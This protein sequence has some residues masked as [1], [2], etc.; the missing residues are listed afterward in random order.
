MVRSRLEPV[1]AFRAFQDLVTAGQLEALEE[2]PRDA[3]SEN[4]IITHVYLSE[5]DSKVDEL[6]RGYHQQYPLRRGIAR[7]ELKSRLKIS[8]RVFQAVIRKLAAHGAIVE[9]ANSIALPTHAIVFSRSQ[10]ALIDSLMEKFAQNPATP[11]SVKECVDELG[12]EVFN[13]L[14]E[15]GPLVSVSSEVVFRNQDYDS[16]IARIRSYLK[17]HDKVSLAEVRDLF[18]TSR[19]Y[20]QALLEHLDTLGV[21]VRDGDYRKLRQ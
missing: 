13:A 2:S 8:S 11:P 10:Q 7:E 20:A 19:K 3:T 1:A 17:N 16:M 9:V 12:E 21:T 15:A 6:V 18:K 5:V 4:L 14:I